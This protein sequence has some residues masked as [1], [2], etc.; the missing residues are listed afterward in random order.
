MSIV[1]SGLKAGL[2]AIALVAGVLVMSEGMQRPAIAAPVPWQE[3]WDWFWGS[4]EPRDPGPGGLRGGRP[5]EGVCLVTPR[6]LQAVWHL[7]PTFVWQGQIATIGL[8]VKDASEVWRQSIAPSDSSLTRQVRYS[9]TALQPGQ[10][11]DWLFFAAPVNPL[12]QTWATFQVMDAK[13]HAAI[14]AELTTLEADLKTQQAT[15][16]AIALQRTRYFAQKKMWADALQEVYSVDS[17]SPELQQVAEAIAQKI[18]APPK[19]SATQNP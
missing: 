19:S 8:R 12:P 1:K 18:C 11:Y 15:P 9:G 7:N 17:P 6:N 4:A 5:I 3:A 13:E 2:S 10:A 14:A 16:E